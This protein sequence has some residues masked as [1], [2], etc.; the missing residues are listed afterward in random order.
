MSLYEKSSVS[1][2]QLYL[3]ILFFKSP[4][5]RAKHCR[6]KSSKFGED[7]GDIKGICYFRGDQYFRTVIVI[8]SG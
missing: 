2:P 4:P 5:K 8:L 3:E 1:G 6:D 7:P